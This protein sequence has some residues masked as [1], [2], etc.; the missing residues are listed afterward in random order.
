M[1]RR[2]LQAIAGARHGGA[3]IFF[4]RLAAAAIAVLRDDGL[5]RS[6]HLAS[7]GRQR[8]LSWDRVAAEFE[9]LMR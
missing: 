1:T 4:V 6:W 9:S 7:L 8:G 2:L 5:W 3:E